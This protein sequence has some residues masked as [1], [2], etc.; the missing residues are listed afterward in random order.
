MDHFGLRNLDELPNAEELRRI[1]LPA[2]AAQPGA[3][4]ADPKQPSQ[5]SR[6]AA[7]EENPAG[8]QN[9]QTE[10]KSS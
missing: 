7:E 4:P 9:V 10:Q 6:G 3:Q 1:R 5:E 8:V 2:A